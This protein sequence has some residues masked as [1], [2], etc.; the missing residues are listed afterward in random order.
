MP[1]KIQNNL[2]YFKLS[3]ENLE[4]SLDD[5]YIFDKKHPEINQYIQ[6]TKEIK[7]ILITIKTLERKKEKFQLIN[8][9]YNELQKTFSK[10]SNCSEFICFVNACDN[11]LDAVKK[12]LSL[13]KKITQR[14]F[15][16]RLLNE[17]VPEEGKNRGRFSFS[18]GIRRF[19]K[20]KS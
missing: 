20:S 15:S 16:K 3:Q 1:K 18:R 7:N 5:F 4:K 6:N 12:D 10:F 9:Y 2:Y 8:K 17:I 14:Y 11:T 13:I 19:K